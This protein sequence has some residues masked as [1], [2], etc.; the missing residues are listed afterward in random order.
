M[1]VRQEDAATWAGTVR[2]GGFASVVCGVN[3]T[4]EG[5][6]AARQAAR[7]TTDDG[8]LLLLAVAGFYAALAGRW[9]PETSRWRMAD[10]AGRSVEECFADLRRRA[11]ASLSAARAQATATADGAE[12][13]TRV[14]DGD[15]DA[16][17]LEAA[18][19]EA[20]SL[21]AVGTHGVRRLAGAALGETTAMVLHE[22]PVS[23]LVARPPFDPARFPADIVVG[24]DGSPEARAA[25]DL[26]VGLRRRHGGT[27]R[28]VSA[29]PDAR[30][31]A[32]ALLERG[33]ADDLPDLL[34]SQRRPVNALVNAAQ[35]ADLL[36]VGSR[37]LHGARAL[38]SVSERVAHRAASSV[39]V[40]RAPGAAPAG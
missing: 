40:V 26:A 30:G 34:V 6:E 9:G 19:D 15:A 17:L 24:M 16:R 25:L 33:G 8:R 36:V 35:T 14:A 38:G 3:G 21:V 29:G 7:L 2:R 32:D 11:G 10:E 5:F 13:S 27:L 28:I 20:A 12:V 4:R 22:S 31:A 23:V 1:T 39:L 18:G 37:G